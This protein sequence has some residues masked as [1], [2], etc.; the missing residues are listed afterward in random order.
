MARGK[1][2]LSL[3]D[4]F[5]REA[6][7]ST[8]PANNHQVRD[9][10]VGLLQRTQQWLYE[11]FYWP[12]LEI[13]RMYPAD[14]GQ[15]F[16]D[17]NQDFDISRIARIEFKTD[18]EWIPLIHGIGAAQYAEFD[19]DLDER[20][21][22]VRRWRL[23]E[24]EQIEVWPIPENEP[25]P[26]TL[27][28]YLRVTGIKR[29][30]P[31]VDDDDRAV[32]DNRLIVLYAAGEYLLDTNKDRAQLLLQLAQ[33]HYARIRGGLMPGGPINVFGVNAARSPRRHIVP[34]YRPAGS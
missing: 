6:R 4:D 32:L 1:T 3:L 25:D 14:A 26:S 7:L 11:D 15:R 30:P 20:S 23:Y 18:G 31:L 13:Q 27:D 28:G 21:W 9:A 8:N 12:H 16:Y 19:S 29:L 5:R 34:Y 22:P 17:F 2:L 10:Q 33:K 24:D